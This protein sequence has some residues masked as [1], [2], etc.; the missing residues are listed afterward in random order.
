MFIVVE[1]ELSCKKSLP[2][3]KEHIKRKLIM[4]ATK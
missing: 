4:E 3:E 2:N 1:R